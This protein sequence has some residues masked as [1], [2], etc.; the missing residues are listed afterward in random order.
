MMMV[1]SFT[2]LFLVAVCLSTFSFGSLE[3][4]TRW[5]YFC[6][7]ATTLTRNIVY[8]ANVD[9]LFS[10][11]STNATEHDGFF[12]TTAGQE[13]NMVYG[14]FLCRG[15]ARPEICRDCINLAAAD[16]AKLCPNQSWAIIWYNKCMLRYSNRS[17]F[18]SMAERPNVSLS[19]RVDAMEPYRF[20]RLVA[21]VMKDIATRAPNARSRTKK[22]ATKEATFNAFQILYSLAQ[23]TPDISS[24]DCYR[25]LQ[26]AIADLQFY[27]GGKQS[28]FAMYPSCTAQYRTSPFYSLNQTGLAKPP[29]SPQHPLL[30]PPPPPPPP[31]KR[32]ISSQT[33]I[34]I[35]VSTVGFL[36][37]S[38]FL[39]GVL[40]WKATKKLTARK[41][42]N[43]GLK[44]K[45][46]QSLRFDLSIIEAATKN[47]AEVNKIGAGGFGSVY[48]GILTDGQEI[49]VKRL[50]TSSGQGA[51]EFQTEVVL[52]AKLQHRNLVKLLG[53]CLERTERMLIYEFVPNK[54][55]DHFIFDL[56][57]QRQLV[58]PLRY[59]IIKGIARGLLYLHSDSRLKIIH[60]DLKAGNILL[61]K[62]MTPKISDFG[63]AKIVGENKSLQ[64]TKRIAGTYGYMSPEYAVHGRFSEKSDV[65]SFGILMLEIVCG[66]RNTSFCHSAH[67]ENLLTYVWRQWKNGTPIEVMDSALGDSYVSNE[68]AR[69][70]HIALLCVQ[71]DPEARPP[72]AKVVLMLSSSSVT[73]PLPQRTAFYFGTITEGKPSIMNYKSDQ[74]TSSALATVNETS[75]TELFPR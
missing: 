64:H 3:D 27:F 36:V 43:D 24:E 19:Y 39:C 8:A 69:C 74:S 66:K 23:C 7:N 5:Y 1:D 41:T 38:C 26:D 13:P 61:D 16:V 20:N 2:K 32:G 10:Y 72:M 12:N 11:L 18:S 14:L 73:L 46:L 47:F 65:Y 50:S 75:L 56:E 4:P 42:R 30:L 51:D 59:K 70:I 28:G 15:D 55:L 25:C 37:L 35:V 63:M 6:S 71:Q 21:T 53:Y 68:V 40:G 57:K 29:V 17:I 67:A 44:A 9:Q 54:S 52:V 48:K 22:F 31:G 34:K 49:A 62:D 33:V 58:W 60:R 45:A